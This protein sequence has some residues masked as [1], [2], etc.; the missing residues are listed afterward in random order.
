MFRFVQKSDSEKHD[1]MW[2]IEQELHA[3]QP[4]ARP[5]LAALQNAALPPQASVRALEP[6]A[7]TPA[8]K[9]Q[10]DT[11]TRLTETQQTKPEAKLT[12]TQP[13]KREGEPQKEDGATKRSK[14]SSGSAASGKPKTRDPSRS[15]PPGDSVP[16]DEPDL[17]KQIRGAEAKAK[18]LVNNLSALTVQVDEI[19]SCIAEQPSWQYL[20]NVP[21]YATFIEAKKKLNEEKAKY[22]AKKL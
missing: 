6:I 14:G 4:S 19:A 12:E 7:D 21:H 16:S 8:S 10:T 2:D 15:P 22:P 18:V 3:S 1:R 5:S 20:A 13:T 17:N 9:S 11:S